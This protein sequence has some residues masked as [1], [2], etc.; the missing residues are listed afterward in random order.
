M[1]ARIVVAVAAT[2]VAG[3]TWGL[4][5][6]LEDTLYIP[7]DD[8]AI[9]YGQRPAED[10]VA[11]LQQRIERGEATLQTAPN[12]LGYLPAVLK[13]LGIN[14]DSQALVFSKT[15]TQAEKIGPRSPRA[16]YF[17]DDVTVGFVRDSDVLEIASLDPQQ[18]V[19]FYVLVKTDEPAFAHSEGC[20]RCH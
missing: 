18:G 8:P 15:S 19:Q 2:L 14:A 7:L 5:Q 13:Q 17:N 1:N 4:A 20:L 10:P 16:I 6:Q 9:Q 12:G 3:V 11:R